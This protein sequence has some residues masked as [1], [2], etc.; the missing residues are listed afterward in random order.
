[1]YFTT[2]ILLLPIPSNL[3]KTLEFWPSR[4]RDGMGYIFCIATVALIASLRSLLNVPAAGGAESST[5]ACNL[6]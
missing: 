1:M 6:S 4:I 5:D 3:N 2:R